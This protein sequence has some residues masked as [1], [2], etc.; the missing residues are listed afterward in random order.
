VTAP[1][2]AL[3]VAVV[4][5]GDISSVHFDAILANRDVQLVAVCDI[6][7]ALATVTGRR[8]GAAVYTDLT[9]MLT[10]VRPDVV[11][12]CTPH[13]LH[14]RMAIDCLERGIH[15][16]LEKPLATTVADGEAILR[17]AARSTAI[18]GVCFQNRY[19]ATSRA[20]RALLDGGTLGAVVGG[21][22]SVTWF[23]SAD[24]YRRRPWR[25]TWAAGG[26]GVLLNQAIHTLDLLQWYL[27]DVEDVR[28]QA[29]RLSLPDPVEVE[30]TAC[31]QLR[32]NSGA[33]SI[34]YASNGY[35]DNAPVSLEILTEQ[36]TLRLD[37]DL[38]VT[39]LDGTVE[40]T[41]EPRVGSGEKAYWGV[42][43]GLLID[44]FYR[45][46]RAGQ[47]FWID[48]REA[49]KTLRIITAVYEQSPLLFPVGQE[50]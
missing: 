17:A 18:I 16:L 50:V 12:I 9:T 35:L 34:F 7:A 46:V 29:S 20:L 26:G 24:Y 49:L 22:G 44:D 45:Q 5:C 47:P 33:G 8:L 41:A 37:T 3:R 38:A 36:A 23:R 31:L 43:H 4:G 32:H 19:N 39:Y 27:G 15:V 28:G 13:H 48:A 11:H 6:D 1:A 40:V 10:S 25:G 2:G 30:D 42:S 14:A 21:R